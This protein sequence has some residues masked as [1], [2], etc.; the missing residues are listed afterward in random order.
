M[1]A[2]FGR[3]CRIR[4][5]QSFA[6]HYTRYF[7]L[8]ITAAANLRSNRDNDLKV[9]YNRRAAFS[10]MIFNLAAIRLSCI[11]PG[12]QQDDPGTLHGASSGSSRSAAP[13]LGG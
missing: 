10:G 4:P 3:N 13:A 1:N 9:R 11:P 8:A 5:V 7:R 6:G 12:G 2:D